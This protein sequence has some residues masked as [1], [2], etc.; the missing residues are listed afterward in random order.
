MSLG[1]Q[2]VVGELGAVEGDGAALPVG[3][4]GRRVRVDE[5]PVR[6][7]GLRPPNGLP[8]AALEA[9]AGVVQRDDVQEEDVAEGRV[10][11]RE[12]QPEPGEHPS[13]R[14]RRRRRGG[15]YGRFNII[16]GGSLHA[17]GSKFADSHSPA[18]LGDYHLRA[19]GAELFPQ[20]R[21]LQLHLDLACGGFGGWVVGDGR[22]GQQPLGQSFGRHVAGGRERLRRKVCGK[23]KNLAVNGRMC[24]SITRC[25]RQTSGI[26][27]L[28]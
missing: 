9:I 2:R 7:L 11:A 8:A 24:T 21:V 25:S 14:R 20:V 6:Q 3:P 13:E 17:V 27:F 22:G 4:C 15:G 19:H 26:R 18:L 28:S 1:V 10:Q 12:L 23:D 16:G 5:N